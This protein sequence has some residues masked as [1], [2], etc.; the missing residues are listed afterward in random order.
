VT[1]PQGDYDARRFG[2]AFVADGDPAQGVLEVA[3]TAEQVDR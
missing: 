1:R 2:E 3:W